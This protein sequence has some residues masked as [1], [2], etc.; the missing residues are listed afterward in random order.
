MK[1]HIANKTASMLSQNKHSS[2]NKSKIK[3]SLYILG[4]TESSLLTHE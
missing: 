1:W 4:E 3:I 2:L